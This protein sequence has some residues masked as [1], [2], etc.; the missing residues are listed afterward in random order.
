MQ[1]PIRITFRDMP[2]SDA[3]EAH[4]RRRSSRLERHS[5][6]I[7]DCHVTIEMPHR[8]HTHGRPIHVSVDLT[9]PGT[10]LV[11]NRLREDDAA[12]Q[13]AYAA[14]DRAFDHAVRRLEHYVQLR[15]P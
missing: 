15:R 14:I 10:K 8:H 13:D 7:D 12:S 5:E 9:V 4:V 2:S 11:A 1:L 3:I 6:L